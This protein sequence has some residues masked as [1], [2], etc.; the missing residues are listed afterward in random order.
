[1]TDEPSAMRTLSQNQNGRESSFTAAVRR[2][3]GKCVISGK[4]NGR[5]KQGNWTS[6]EAAHIFVAALAVLFLAICHAPTEVNR[7]QVEVLPICNPT[8]RDQLLKASVALST[9]VADLDLGNMCCELEGTKPV[10]EMDRSALP[11]HAPVL[12]LL[13]LIDKVVQIR[14]IPNTVGTW[15]D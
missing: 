7:Q 2:R 15:R 6:W 12:A 3:D 11:Q 8:P 4:I 9:Y 1:M 14:Q 10:T 5:A 13:E